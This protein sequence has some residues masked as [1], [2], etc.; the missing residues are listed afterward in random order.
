MKIYKAIFRLDYPLNYALLDK[1][2]EHLEFIKKETKSNNFKSVKYD[3]NLINHIITTSG[4]FGEMPFILNITLKNFDGTLEFTNGLEL[5]EISKLKFFN[6]IDLVIKKLE[7]TNSTYE[8]IGFRTYGIHYSEKTK[9]TYILDSIVSNNK[10]F[11]DPFENHFRTPNDV[12]LVIEAIDLKE[13]SLRVTLGPFKNEE[14]QKYFSIK[15]EIKEGIIFDIDSFQMK[16]DLPGFKMSN[17][18]SKNETLQ[19]NI[20]DGILK[21]L[22]I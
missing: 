11:T 10:K 7:V 13:D 9:F 5:Q 22:N 19:K 20:I 3:I 12:A 16:L 1:L 8:R 14:W 17:F 2:G 4:L 21:N 6:F 15:P 18:V